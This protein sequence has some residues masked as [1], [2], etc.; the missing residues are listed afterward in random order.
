MS[1][2]RGR[3]PPPVLGEHSAEFK[4]IQPPRK[5]LPDDLVLDIYRT[6]GSNKELA[7]RF[8]VNRRTVYGI[9]HH[10]IHAQLIEDF[11]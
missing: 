3:R 7:E 8:N 10:E 11:A 9:K 5:P 2:F 1:K 4:L 6:P